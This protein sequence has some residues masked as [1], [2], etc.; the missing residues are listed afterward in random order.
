MRG[1][2]VVVLVCRYMS[3]FATRKRNNRNGGKKGSSI[4]KD[5]ERWRASGEADRRR[6]DE[7]LRLAWKPVVASQQTDSLV[8]ATGGNLFTSFRL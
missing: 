7:V 5:A 2:H 3:Q 8:V 6:P 4:R 1:F